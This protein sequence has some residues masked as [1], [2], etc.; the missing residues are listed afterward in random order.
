MKQSVIDEYEKWKHDFVRFQIYGSTLTHQNVCIQT[1]VHFKW[2][3]CTSL[4]NH[5]NN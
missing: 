3:I 4:E 5:A 1:I 2:I